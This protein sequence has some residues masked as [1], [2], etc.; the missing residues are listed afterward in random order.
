M[1]SPNQPIN[2]HAS[3]KMSWT[4]Y[5]KPVFIFLFLLIISSSFSSY[6]LKFS[7]FIFIISLCLFVFQILTIRSVNLYTDDDGVWVYSGI[8][9]WSKGISGVKWRDLDDAGYFTNFTSWLFKSYTVR[10]GHRFTKESEIV[11]PHIAM[12]HEAV[13]EINELHRKIL[14]V[15]HES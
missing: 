2:I 11:L 13:V 1:E 14:T 4:A 5:V 12:G 15:I 3:Y 6:S 8:L 7:A 10:V 9:P